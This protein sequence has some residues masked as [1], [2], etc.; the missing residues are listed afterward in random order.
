MP[1]SYDILGEI[2]AGTLGF[3]HGNVGGAKKFIKRYKQLRSFQNQVMAPTRKQSHLNF[4]VR[5]HSTASSSGTHKSRR[6]S[7]PFQQPQSLNPFAVGRRASVTSLSAASSRRMSLASSAASGNTSKSSGGNNFMNNA[8]KGR[9]RGKIATRHRKIAKVDSKFRAKVKNVLQDKG[10]QGVRVELSNDYFNLGAAQ[11][12]ATRKFMF[13]HVQENTMPLVH[14]TPLQIMNSAAILFANKGA[15]QD[16]TV[17]AG[18]FGDSEDSVFEIIS[19]KAT[20]LFKNN[21]QRHLSF[22]ITCLTPKENTDAIVHGTIDTAIAADVSAGTWKTN[23]VPIDKASLVVNWQSSPTLK[24]YY[25]IEKTTIKLDPG[26]SSD[27]TVHGYTGKFNWKKSIKQDQTSAGIHWKYSKNDTKF[28]V[29]DVIPN[30][31]ACTAA[32]EL[33]AANKSGRWVALTGDPGHN[34]GME[35]T[36]T[37][38]IQAPRIKPVTANSKIR[39]LENYTSTI[40]LANRVIGE[41]CTDNYAEFIDA[42][43]NT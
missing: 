21:T 41:Q 16:Y 42:I 36:E 19:Q 17:T 7:L 15:T 26:A 37:I 14:F 1:K 4:P 25:K 31:V 20:Y 12:R 24:K 9:K 2:S 40:S 22:T 13:A 5:R 6:R 43:K 38:T 35:L 3:I 34:L 29:F 39:S 33:G 18:N 27:Y 30:M 8:T 28:L 23:A 11:V 10:S 32:D